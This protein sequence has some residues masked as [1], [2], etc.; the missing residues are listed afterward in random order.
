MEDG[1]GVAGDLDVEGD[2]RITRI[3]CEVEEMGKTS[4]E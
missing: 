4:L 3:S 2:L 1:E